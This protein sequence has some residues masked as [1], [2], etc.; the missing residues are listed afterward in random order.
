LL[1]D[2]SQAASQLAAASQGL[3]PSA[4]QLK[5]M[6]ARVAALD[7]QIS[8]LQAEMAGSG[9]TGGDDLATARTRFDTLQ[10][11]NEVAE[12]RYAAAA[13]ALQAARLAADRQRVYINNFV[14]PSLPQSPTAP[15]RFFM[16]LAVAFG[17]FVIWALLVG[18]AGLI[19]KQ[20]V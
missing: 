5:A 17:S 9:K 3:S 2:R 12:K 11:D 10:L 7:E 20:M 19:R 6:R 14:E 15:S 8:K 13:S 1:L 16:S 18:L 4:P